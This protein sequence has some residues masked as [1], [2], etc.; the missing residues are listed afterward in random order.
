MAALSTPDI[1]RIMQGLSFTRS[2]Q[3]VIYHSNLSAHRVV[4]VSSILYLH[5]ARLTTARL[6]SYVLINDCRASSPRHK[7]PLLHAQCYLDSVGAPL[8]LCCSLPCPRLVCG[9]PLPHNAELRFSRPLW[10]CRSF[11]L[12]LCSNSSPS[13][14]GLGCSIHQCYSNKCQQRSSGDQYE[15]H[16]SPQQ[17]SSLS[18]WLDARRY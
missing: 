16:V 14:S 15:R 18:V 13:A 1:L 8:L 2:S 6:P 11:T 17:D 10:P 4:F 9:C 5:H 12:S 3:P 7:F